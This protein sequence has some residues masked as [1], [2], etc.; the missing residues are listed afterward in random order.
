MPNPMVHWEIVSNDAKRAQDFYANRTDWHV[1][2]VEG[3]DYGIVDT[4]GEGGTNG[5]IGNQQEEAYRV[6][7]YVQVEDL[8][9]ALDK[10]ESLGGKT[11][12]PPMEIPGVV[13]LAQFSDPDGN[14]IG[15]VKG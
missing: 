15:L 5:G 8:Q 1:E 9:A 7:F 10:A 6:T 14:I 13:T 11:V 4:H 3:M 12:T 2:P